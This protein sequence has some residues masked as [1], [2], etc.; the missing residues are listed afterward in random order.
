MYP[1]V[2]SMQSSCLLCKSPN[3]FIIVASACAYALYAHTAIRQ[4]KRYLR[5]SLQVSQLY[6]NLGIT[7]CA[8][9]SS[10]YSLL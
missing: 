6:L 3:P 2:R 8:S 10:L 9:H 1:I 7:M 4:R 5:V